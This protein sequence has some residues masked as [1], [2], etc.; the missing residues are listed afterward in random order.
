VVP[1]QLAWASG[2]DHT[3]DAKDLWPLL[4]EANRAVAEAYGLGPDDFEHILDAFPVFGR[5]RPE[6]FA[7]LQDRLA[8][9][10]TNSPAAR[11]GPV[12]SR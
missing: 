11:P 4:W 8:G 2:I 5:K 1:T 7:Y 10:K 6:F 3:T 12:G 9:W